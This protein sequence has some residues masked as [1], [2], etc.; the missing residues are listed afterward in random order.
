MNFRHT[1][2]GFNNSLIMMISMS[3]TSFFQ[4]ALVD[5]KQLFDWISQNSA[6]RHASRCSVSQKYLYHFWAPFDT[7][8]SLASW[9]FTSLAA[10]GLRLHLC[11]IRLLIIIATTNVLTLSLNRFIFKAASRPGGS[12]LVAEESDDERSGEMDVNSIFLIDWLNSES[13]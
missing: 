12:N 9:F 13:V 5:A 2:W 10:L 11:F 1:C 6:F 8:D 3:A 4:F 7:S